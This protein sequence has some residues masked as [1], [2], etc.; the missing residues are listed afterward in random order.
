MPD[1]L[2]RNLNKDTVDRLK[3]RAA[4]SGRSLQTEAKDILE[5]SAREMTH[6]ELYERAVRFSR[7]FEGRHFTDSVELLRE[8]RKR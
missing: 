7:R 1:I 8:D 3:A 5:R 4:E 6:R 2:V